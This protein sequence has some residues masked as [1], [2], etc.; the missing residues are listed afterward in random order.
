MLL[1]ACVY[2]LQLQLVRQ[3]HSKGVHQGCVDC[4]WPVCRSYKNGHVSLSFTG[5]QVWQ[6]KSQQ[7]PWVGS[8]IFQRSV[9]L[10]NC[11]HAP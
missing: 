5:A 7:I 2:A 4:A 1:V 6:G 8:D 10:K 3:H 11:D 9:K